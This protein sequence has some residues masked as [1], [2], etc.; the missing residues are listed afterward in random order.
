MKLL[1]KFLCDGK[2]QCENEQDCMKILKDLKNMFGFLDEDLDCQKIDNDRKET[3]EKMAISEVATERVPEVNCCP[4]KNLDL[5]EEKM[6]KIDGKI[7]EESMESKMKSEEKVV[8]SEAQA[9]N[10][11]KIYRE[12]SPIKSKKGKARKNVAKS[13]I[14]GG[15]KEESGEK[16]AVSE[17]PTTGEMPKISK[18]FIRIIAC[19]ICFTRQLLQWS[20]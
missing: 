17:G 7:G 18:F 2:I 10:I 8:V 1:V 3:N 9:K 20:F 12:I 15:K 16:L 14:S 13:I 19:F 5:P 6:D 4:I 11:P